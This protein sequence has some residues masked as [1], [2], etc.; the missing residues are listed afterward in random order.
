MTQEIVLKLAKDSIQ[1]TLMIGGPLML[2]SLVVG[3]LVSIVQVVTSIHDM[4][5]S[6]V[7]RMLAVFVVFL[8]ILPWMMKLLTGF[9]T[10]LF[11]HLERFAL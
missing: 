4:T 10:Q 5:L 3:I 2:V 6:L 1:I 8:L 9:S 11:G 7:P